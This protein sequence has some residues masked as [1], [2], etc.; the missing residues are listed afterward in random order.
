MKHVPLTKHLLARR[1]W[2]PLL[3]LYTRLALPIVLFGPWPL[4]RRCVYCQCWFEKKARRQ[5]MTHPTNP[6]SIVYD[7][8]AI[9][10]TLLGPAVRWKR[11]LRQVMSREIHPSVR[12]KELKPK[13]PLYPKSSGSGTT[14][15]K[16]HF[17][18]GYDPSRN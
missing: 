15:D 11:A 18:P 3:K 1:F 12:H 5:R 7:L 13:I 9:G 10:T 2:H 17:T 16:I 8:A 6:S 14:S 4:K